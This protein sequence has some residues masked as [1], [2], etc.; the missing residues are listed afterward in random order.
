MYKAR[1]A[2]FAGNQVS[3]TDRTRNQCSTLEHSLPNEARY[4]GFN[5]DV[6]QLASAD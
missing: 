2:P 6:G 1:I 3:L 4:S 5:V